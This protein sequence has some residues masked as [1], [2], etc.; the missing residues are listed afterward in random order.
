[1][2][3]RPL[4]DPSVSSNWDGQLASIASGTGVRAVFASGN[5]LD[6]LEGGSPYALQLN[7]S[8]SFSGER[9]DFRLPFWRG[10]GLAFND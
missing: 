5:M 10:E 7:P 2:S 9:R 4:V 3:A 8:Q 1:M 6:V